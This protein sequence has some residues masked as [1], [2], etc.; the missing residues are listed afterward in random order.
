[1]N[2]LMNN[3]N[4]IYPGIFISFEGIDGAGKS[5]HIRFFSDEIA[6]RFPDKKIVLTREPGGTPLGEKLRET[7]L[8]DSMDIRTEAL[9]MF[10][11][12][13][14]HLAQLIEPALRQGDIVISDRFTDSSFA[15]QCGGRG[16]LTKDLEELERWVQTR[17]VDN[18]SYLLQPQ[19]TFL[20]D[21]SPQ[22]AELRRSATRNPDKFEELDLDFFNRVRQEYL[23][24][25]SNHPQ[26]FVLIDSSL[27]I[28]TIQEQLKTRIASM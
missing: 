27:S 15:Y 25:A 2:H 10:A 24:R 5:T 22:A 28:S 8:N 9:L 14:E 21:L 3:Q 18:Q 26:R 17:M 1:M 6:K 13:Q 16:L 20:F 4:Q 23:R 11:S 19:T 12:R 7:L